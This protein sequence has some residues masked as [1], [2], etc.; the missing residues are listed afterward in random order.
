MV[1]LLVVMVLGLCCDEACLFGD[2]KLVHEAL[3]VE[4]APQVGTG[5]ITPSLGLAK[6]QF[7]ASTYSLPQTSSEDCGSLV[8]LV[9]I[10]M[11]TTESSNTKWCRNQWKLMDKGPRGSGPFD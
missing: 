3:D 5:G 11:G 10:V 2:E 9:T 4:T 7:A 8:P 1:D 6:H